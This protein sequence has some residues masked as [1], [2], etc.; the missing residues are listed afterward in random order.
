MLCQGA[1]PQC[2]TL[3]A[4]LPIDTLIK[5]IE[6]ATLPLYIKRNEKDKIFFKK[7]NI[8]KSTLEILNHYKDN[9]K[10]GIK[11]VLYQYV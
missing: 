2:N 8:S 5:E 4:D 11:D 6:T 9:F 10:N 1:S 7:D 3:N